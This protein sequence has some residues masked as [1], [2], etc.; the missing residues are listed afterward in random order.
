MTRGTPRDRSVLWTDGVVYYTF[1]K[2]VNDRFRADIGRAIATV[3]SL[4]CLKFRLHTNENDYIMF[5]SRQSESCSSYIGRTGGKQ[6]LE[7][8]PGCKDQATILHEICHAL[9]MW[10]EQSR[11]DRDEYVQ[12]LENNIKKGSHYDFMKRSVFM[13]DSLGTPYDYGSVMHYELDAFAKKKSLDTMKVINQEEYERQGEP[14]VGYAPT[15][16]KLDVTQ[17]NRLH[18]CPGSGIQGDLRVYIERA[19]NLKPTSNAYVIVTA[20]DD[21][22]RHVAMRT[23]YIESTADPNWDTWLDF[24]SRS[25]WQYIDVSIWDYDLDTGDTQLT[26]TQTFYLNP[27]RHNHTHCNKRKCGIKMIFSF[28]LTQECH[29]FN[30]GTCLSDGACDCPSKYGG[31]QCEYLHGQLRIYVLRGRNLR[32]KDRSSRSESDPYLEVTAFDH[33]GGRKTMCTQVISDNLNPVW[34]EELDFGENEWSW[35]TVQA[36]D[37]DPSYTEQ[38]SYAYTYPLSSYCSKKK[39]KMNGFQGFVV[40]NYFFEP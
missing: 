32:D 4:T 10:H 17:L 8:G 38:L 25:S 15:L 23:S 12:V 39:V 40:F 34:N 6:K 5:S 9:G 14:E 3:E 27:G 30:G 21:E 20:H 1:H 35:F 11:P 18:N 2:S 28:T 36:F 13:V 37:D 33:H 16:S 26:N 31:P 7:L 29:C 24:G 22:R 19:E